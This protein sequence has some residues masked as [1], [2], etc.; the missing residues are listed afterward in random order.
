MALLCR[1]YKIKIIPLPCFLNR[2]CLH[3]DFFFSAR[4][5]HITNSQLVSVFFFKLLRLLLTT[6]LNRGL[7]TH[8]RINGTSIRTAST[9]WP[10]AVT[11]TRS[12]FRT[13]KTLDQ[14]ITQRERMWPGHHIRMRE[15]KQRKKKKQQGKQ[16]ERK[17]TKQN[18]RATSALG[19]FLIITSLCS[20]QLLPTGC[21]R[22][23]ALY[24][25]QRICV[26]PSV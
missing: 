8:L 4:I 15:L 7:R 10:T 3:L 11:T 12:A 24:M 23:Y 17:T 1:L 18:G 9:Y 13:K 26:R 20:A 25:M 19:G 21:R 5:A 22:V 14:L 16:R 2:Q 6:I